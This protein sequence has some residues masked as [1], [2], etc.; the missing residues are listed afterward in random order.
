MEI[1]DNTIYFESDGEFEDFCVAP[2][3]I[4]KQTSRGAYFWE[5][6]YTDMYKKSV[7]EGVT[8]VIKDTNSKV[9]ER[10]CVCKRVPV[11]GT[12][13]IALVQ[14][15]VQNLGPYYGDY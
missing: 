5:G 9:Y 7:E 14:L 11:Q 12:N 4:I 15:P 13:R 2:Y 10:G 8:F 1:R 3:A 6:E